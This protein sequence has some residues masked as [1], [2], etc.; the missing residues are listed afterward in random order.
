M[1]YETY[2]PS[3]F[4]TTA[5]SDLASVVQDNHKLLSSKILKPTIIF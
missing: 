3:P 4:F 2:L 1:L 5:L